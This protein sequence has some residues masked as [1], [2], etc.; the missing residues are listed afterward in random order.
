V[1]IVGRQLLVSAMA[2]WRFVQDRSQL[3]LFAG[4]DEQSNRF[5]PDDPSNSTRG[6]RAGIRL[7]ADFWSEPIDGFMV[8]A[9]VSGSTIGPSVWSRIA[10]GTRVFGHLWFGPEFQMMGDG[11][12]KQFRAGVHLTAFRTGRFEWSLGF[13]YANDSD[14]KNGIYGRIGM[15]TRH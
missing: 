4:S 11:R 5:R 8:L 10:A 2:G 1:P 9:S 14:H 15:L 7:G 6:G 13:G 3:T 12:Y